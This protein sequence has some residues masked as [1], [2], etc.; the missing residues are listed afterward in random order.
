MW[1]SGFVREERR[2]RERETR[3]ELRWR[4][5]GWL[6]KPSKRCQKIYIYVCIFGK[7]L[8]IMA[9]TIKAR[10][11]AHTRTPVRDAG[12]CLEG[13]TQYELFEHYL[14]RARAFQ[15]KQLMCETCERSVR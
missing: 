13:G 8:L 14:K 11:V 5:W 9:A 6:M 15:L 7:L 4:R 12:V 1:M 3:R 10:Q 2:E